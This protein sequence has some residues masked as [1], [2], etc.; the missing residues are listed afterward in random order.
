V[1]WGREDGWIPLAHADRFVGAI[2]GARKVVI[3]GCGHVPQEE[4]PGEVLELLREHLR[5]APTDGGARGVGG[6]TGAS[7]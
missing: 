1:I 6:V 3:D 7:D 4:K 2:A 5:V